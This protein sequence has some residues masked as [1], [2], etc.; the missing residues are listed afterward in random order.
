MR[1]RPAPFEIY[2]HFKGNLY[3][4][5]AIAKDSEDGHECVVYQGM[6]GDFTIYVRALDEFLSP[7]D[8][9]KYP[10]AGQEYRFEKIG[11][12]IGNENP[13]EAAEEKKFEGINKVPV[14]EPAAAEPVVRD[15]AVS[16]TAASEPAENKPVD[17]IQ[18]DPDGEIDPRVLAYLD[19]DTY[20]ERLN[21]LASLKH[22]ITDE[23]LNTMAIVS[24]IELDPGP[25]E[26]RYE[27][28]RY[29]LLTKDKFE[30]VR[31]R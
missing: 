28:L 23:M 10:D 16:K 20:E 27:S 30:R 4:I 24:D 2:K 11:K 12:N 14:K 7:V 15:Q 31:L 13:K 21:I 26:K 8:T 25:V 29:C 5:I 9:K 1:Q 17:N 19:A 3:Q 22:C 6:Y 18:P